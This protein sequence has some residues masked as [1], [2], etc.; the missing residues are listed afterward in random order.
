MTDLHEFVD[1]F[2]KAVYLDIIDLYSCD[3]K[4]IIKNLL[5][6]KFSDLL[7]EYKSKNRF[8]QKEILNSIKKK[9]NE[10]EKSMI[11]ERCWEVYWAERRCNQYDLIYEILNVIYNKN[12]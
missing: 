11:N 12:I 5:I 1:I 4:D 7:S 2:Y 8:Q 3:N 6:N 9:I 10:I